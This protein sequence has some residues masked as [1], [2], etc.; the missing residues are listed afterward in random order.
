MW[1]DHIVAEVRRIRD[2]L[3]ARFNYDMK[4]IFADMRARRAA[5][6]AGLVNRSKQFE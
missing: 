4:A 3:A 5:R 6:G 1:E 2:E